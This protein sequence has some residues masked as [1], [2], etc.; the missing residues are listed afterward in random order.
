MTCDRVVIINR[1]RLVAQGTP[2]SLTDRFRTRDELVKTASVEVTVQGSPGEIENVIRGTEGVLDFRE[3]RR[4]A[5]DVVSFTIEVASDVDVRRTLAERIVT[6][7]LGLLE[8]HRSRMSLEDVY[9]RA[10]AN[11]AEDAR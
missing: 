8:L 7:G 2:E 10:I 3:S 9:L 5:N 6:R 4:E 1:G 11:D